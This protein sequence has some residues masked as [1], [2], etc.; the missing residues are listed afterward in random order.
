VVTSGTIF[1]WDADIGSV[2]SWHA[3]PTECAKCQQALIT[4]IQARYQQTIARHTFCYT[5]PGN[6]KSDLHKLVR[7]RA[8]FN[9]VDAIRDRLTSPA[10][11]PWR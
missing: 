11:N 4:A 7:A 10:K 3:T 8:E 9:P 6:A 1:G 5:R 2:I